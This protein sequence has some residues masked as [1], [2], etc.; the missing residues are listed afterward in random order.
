MSNRTLALPSQPQLPM[1]SATSSLVPLNEKAKVI[2]ASGRPKAS[3]VIRAASRL[4]GSVPH[5]KPADPETYAAAISAAL[6]DYP[7][8][9]IEECCDPRTGLVRKLDYLPTVK[10]VIDWCDSRLDY[11]RKM[12]NWRPREPEPPP[13]QFSD[14]HRRT[15]LGKLV[16]LFRGMKERR[17]AEQWARNPA[18]SDEALR[19]HYAKPAK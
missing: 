6:A 5:G 8:G 2:L 17:Q 13:L 16:E 7:I 1:L 3:D 18:P 9:V 15:M 12:A 14:E 10:Q 11:H 19:A 4:I